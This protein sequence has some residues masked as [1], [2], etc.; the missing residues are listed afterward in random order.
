ME[1]TTSV[2]RA[3]R[4]LRE[5]R[6][7]DGH[8]LTEGG[9]PE[10]LAE[11]I[12][13]DAV[14]LNDLDPR[15]QRA[16]SVDLAGAGGSAHVEVFWGHFWDSLPCS[17]TFREP[18][19]RRDVMT[20]ADFYSQRQWHATGMYR[21]YLAP[22]GLDGELIIPLPAP[23]GI[24]RR[25]VFFRGPGTPFGD[26][27]RAAAVLLQP[28]IGEALRQHA[29]Q[30]AARR[31]TARQVEL[32]HLVAAGLDNAAI[33]RRLVLSR[34]TVRKHLENVYARLGVT[35]RAAAAAAA[36]PDMTWV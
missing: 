9:V 16:E 17:Y 15:C 2:L 36:F 32:L 20:T 35:S 25:L 24:S 26:T 4:A 11:V 19:L 29:R 7:G 31:L 34:A 21:E 30:A 28:H 18:E 10:S 23:P 12:P 5:A 27:D 13:A 6:H 8:V 14:T 3:V 1:L 22:S 33:A